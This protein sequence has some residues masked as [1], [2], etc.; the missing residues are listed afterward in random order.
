MILHFQHHKEGR[1]FSKR[2]VT[3]NYTN[4]YVYIRITKF[5]H[6]IY[7]NEGDGRNDYHFSLEYKGDKK[8]LA[9]SVNKACN[10]DLLYYHED[11]C[12]L[13]LYKSTFPEILDEMP[14][15]SYMP[16]VYNTTDSTRLVE[17]I[18]YI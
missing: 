5:K 12:E 18:K 10:S 15:E 16:K 2:P 1:D 6:S 14:S 3:G 9:T 13:R 17:I 7:N 11:S 8:E 4:V